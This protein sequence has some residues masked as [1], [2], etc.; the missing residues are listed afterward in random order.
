MINDLDTLLVLGYLALTLSVGLLSS[1]FSSS[2]KDFTSVPSFLRKNKFILAATVFATAVGGGTTFGLSQKIFSENLS[3]AYALILTTPIDLVVA[4]FV[5]PKIAS[6]YDAITAGDIMATEYG[7]TGRIISGI[8]VV[9][10]SVGFLAA[11]ISVSGH[12]LSTILHL[13]YV[14]SVILSYSILVLYTSVGGLRSVITN[15]I[16]QF[17][18][19][20]IAIPILT[21]I[22]IHTI[23]LENFI[24]NIPEQKYSLSNDNILWDT[25]WMTLSFSVMGCY[26]T[27]IQRALLNKNS[28]YMTQAIVIKTIVYVFFIV[29]IALNGL[30]AFQIASDSSSALALQ[31]TINKI[32]PEGIKGIVIIGF[33]SA[34]MSTADTDLNVASL[35]V[36]QD[37]FKP[38][39]KYSS[40][41]LS[42]I[43]RV[44]TVILGTVSIMIS[45]KFESIVDIV[46]HVAGLWA[47]TILVP[48]IATVFGKHISKSGLVIGITSGILSYIAWQFFYGASHML[49]AAF[50]GTIVHLFVFSIL[51]SLQIKRHIISKIKAH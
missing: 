6:Y 18:T 4:F 28:S 23:G 17:L 38:F 48:M 20:I 16:L 45:I 50:V 26:P 32:L 19:M 51:Y 49:S 8:M 30:I 15:N 13:D 37:I 36:A 46:L 5:I 14:T 7:C 24:N 40:V 1:K 12:L 21:I 31:E 29:F 41:N 44:T 35:S 3:Y 27:I 25:I 39:F 43:A 33:L 2:F 22:G 47:P 11:Q 42:F 34:S 10:T 9:I